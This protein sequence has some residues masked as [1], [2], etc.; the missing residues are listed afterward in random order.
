MFDKASTMEI[1]IEEL[2]AKTA[3]VNKLREELLICDKYDESNQHG[4][5]S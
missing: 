2:A 3:E 4:S 1:T 5:A